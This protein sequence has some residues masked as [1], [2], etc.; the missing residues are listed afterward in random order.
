MKNTKKLV[1]M[2]AIAVFLTACGA[3]GA[4]GTETQGAESIETSVTESSTSETVAEETASV[5]EP[6]EVV[7]E[8]VEDA[9]PTSKLSIEE[10]LDSLD[11]ETAT[12]LVINNETGKKTVLKNGE[13]YTLQEGDVLAAGYPEDVDWLYCGDSNNDLYKS[14]EPMYNSY[15]FTLNYDQI[16][17]DT[18]FT[19]SLGITDKGEYYYATVYLSIG[20]DVD[21]SKEPATIA[22]NTQ[23]QPDV[24]ELDVDLS[25]LSN[26]EWVEN[27]KA[28]SFKK[29]T[30][31]VFNVNTGERQVLEDGQQ[32]TLQ[33]GDELALNQP[34]GDWGVNVSV[35]PGVFDEYDRNDY[36]HSMVFN[37]ENCRANL[38]EGEFTEITV[39][40]DDPDGVTQY[41]TLYLSK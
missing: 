13:H 22:V 3:K 28:S 4:Q 10:W 14:V 21:V 5:E 20:N 30:F 35:N 23:E 1:A 19:V 29:M 25:N 15:V 24:E 7:E 37:M 39:G 12:F 31:L 40:C 41:T 33:D 32:Y 17:E 9:D 26:D 16:K 36:F 11:L 18:E 38:T 27:L 6:I 8:P 34:N 2:A